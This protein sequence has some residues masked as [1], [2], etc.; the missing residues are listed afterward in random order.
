MEQLC[1]GSWC[2]YILKSQKDSCYRT[3]VG[4]TNSTIRRIRQHNGIIT[5]GAKASVALIPSEMYC[6]IAGF[7]DHRSA[8]QCEWLLKH[9]TGTR[10]NNKKYSGIAGRI[11]GLNNLILHIDKWATKSKNSPL[12]IWLKLEYIHLLDADDYPTNVTINIFS[13]E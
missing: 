5:G 7:P 1:D 9:P 8:L 4:S 13:I 11:L 12:N 6:I 2:C 3:Y 10:K